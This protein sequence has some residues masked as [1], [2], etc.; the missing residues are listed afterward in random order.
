MSETPRTF[1]NE[2]SIDIKAG[3]IS[4]T[5]KD[6][7]HH[8][9]KVVRIKLTDT[10]IALDGKNTEYEC[11]IINIS[12]P[13]LTLKIMNSVKRTPYPSFNLTLV[14]GITKGDKQD[15]IIQKC[16]ELGVNNIINIQTDRSN[17]QFKDDVSILKKQQRW[18]KVAFNAAKQSKRGSIPAITIIENLK[19]FLDSDIID[20]KNDTILACVET[21]NVT[22][23]KTCLKTLNQ[24]KTNT[25]VLIGPEGGWSP[26]ELDLFKE[27]S[28]K[29]VH[30]GQNILR[31]ETA[32][33]ITIGIV[34]YELE[35]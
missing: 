24:R 7:L 33:I 27:Y 29:Q 32:S 35:L 25:Y 30:L 31:S 15:F 19:S 16:T 14:Q 21:E 1:V 18:Q 13:R 28:L 11:E 4:I 20:L 2:E 23:I 22:S 17:V 12:K 3:L 9:V 5:D 34:L 10:I 26:K 8:L 6:E